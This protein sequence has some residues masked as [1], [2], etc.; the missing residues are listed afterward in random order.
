MHFGGENVEL[1]VGSISKAYERK[2]E[3]GTAFHDMET[4]NRTHVKK[5]QG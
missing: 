5:K 2:T 4:F 3:G 1:R